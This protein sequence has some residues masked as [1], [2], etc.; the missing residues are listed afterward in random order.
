[1]SAFVA[2][3]TRVDRPHHWHAEAKVL[4]TEPNADTPFFEQ[5]MQFFGSTL[6]VIPRV[7]E[8]HVSQFR[9]RCG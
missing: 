6:S 3:D 2:P 5:V 1:M 7:T 4:L 9:L 8:K